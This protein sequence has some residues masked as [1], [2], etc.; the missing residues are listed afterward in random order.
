MAS[1]RGKIAQEKTHGFVARQ[2]RTASPR[3]K[4]ARLR[5]EAK[6]HGFVDGQKRTASSTG[7]IARLCRR[8]KSH[9]FVDGQKRTASSTGKNAR[10]TKEHSNL[11][12]VFEK[13]LGLFFLL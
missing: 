4:N 11:K 3:G 8:A 2:K 12:W 6:T 10:T 5:R 13:I 1:S 9:G 7:K